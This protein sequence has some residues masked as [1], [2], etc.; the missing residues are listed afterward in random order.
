MERKDIKIYLAGPFFSLAD[1]A[2]NVALAKLLRDM[3]YKVTLPQEYAP[4]DPSSGPLSLDDIAS[5]CHTDAVNCDFLVANIDGTDCDSGT[6]LECGLAIHNQ[7]F[8]LSRRGNLGPT[9]KVICVRTDFRTSKRDGVG[10]NAMFRLADR[11]IYMPAFS[12]VT[13]PEAI[14]AMYLRVAD[15]IDKSIKEYM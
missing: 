8:G 4:S 14:E 12:L 10:I 2:H 11:V 3:G 7:Y 9:P 5:M 1:L 15:A 13:T 6:A